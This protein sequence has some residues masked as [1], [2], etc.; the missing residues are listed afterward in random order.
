MESAN[1]GGKHG[2]T[3]G[4]IALGL[5]KMAIDVFLLQKNQKIRK[6]TLLHSLF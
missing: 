6:S 2:K 1:F 3:G 5:E 4:K